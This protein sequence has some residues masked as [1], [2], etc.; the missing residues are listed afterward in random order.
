MGFGGISIW[1]LLLMLFILMP[2]L[3]YVPVVRKAGFVGWWALLIYVPIVNI[4]IF[5]IFAFIKW[6]AEKA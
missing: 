2:L 4:I 3:I 6:P 5:W 1:S